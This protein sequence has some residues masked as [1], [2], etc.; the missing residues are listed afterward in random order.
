MTGTD[1]TNTAKPL[2]AIGVP[3]ALTVSGVAGT[4]AF[5]VAD[6]GPAPVTPSAGTSTVLSLA[7]VEGDTIDGTVA[8]VQMQTIGAGAPGNGA[9]VAFKASADGS[10]YGGWYGCDAP[11]LATGNALIVDGAATLSH[12]DLCPMT[13]GRMMVAYS[14]AATIETRVR[15][16][17]GVWSSAVTAGALVTTDPCALWRGFDGAYYVMA[18][19]PK[20]GIVAGT[21]TMRVARSGD[22]GATWAIQ[23]Y[24]AGIT[25]D[26][27]DDRRLRVA[28]LRGSIVAFLTTGTGVDSVVKQYASTDGVNFTLVSTSA[29]HCVVC[30]VRADVNSGIFYVLTVEQLTGAHLHIRK[31]G[32]ASAS[33]W[34]SAAVEIDSWDYDHP[35]ALAVRDEDGL[36]FAVCQNDGSRDTQFYQSSD[37]GVTWTGGV[38]ANFG[39]TMPTLGAVAASFWRGTLLTV[40]GD[41][42]ATVAVERRY[43]GH[44][45]ATIA[46]A[47]NAPTNWDLV[48]M[49]SDALS[50]GLWT[51]STTGSPTRTLSNLTGQKVV[52]TVSD[53]Q[54]WTYDYGVDSSPAIFRAVMRVTSGV[55]SIMLRC[56]ASSARLEVTLTDTTIALADA[57]SGGSIQT[58]THGISG[59]VDI[60]AVV[61]PANARAFVVFGPYGATDARAYTS[62]TAATTLH[63]YATT[64]IEHEIETSV[65]V[66]AYVQWASV[67]R[68]T[69]T[70]LGNGWTSPTELDPLPLSSRPTYLAGGLSVQ[71]AQGL[72]TLDGVTHTGG[73]TSPY[74]VE[75]AFPRVLP[76]PRTG[77]RSSGLQD[78]TLTLTLD[79]PD[80]PGLLVLDVQGLIGVSKFTLNG[81][82]V[83]LEQ[84][85]VYDG[86]GGRS[87]MPSRSGTTV[88]GPWVRADELRGWRFKTSAGVVRTVTGNSEGSLTRGSTIGEHRAVLYLSDVANT[89]T[90]GS[91]FLYPSRAVVYGHYAAGTTLSTATVAIV[92]ADQYGGATVPEGYREI[93][94]FNLCRAHVVG[95]GADLDD[96]IAI[97]DDANLQTLPN[98]QRYSARRMVD[99]QRVQFQWVQSPHEYR[100]QLGASTSPDYVTSYTS[101]TPV[102]SAQGIPLLLRGI[103]ERVRGDGLN[104]L[105]VPVLVCPS[106]ARK[107]STGLVVKVWNINEVY[108]RIVGPV[109]VE[110]VSYVGTRGTSQIAR[111]AAVTIERER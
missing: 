70:E 18:A 2:F 109:R 23:T 22:D 24:D 97:D 80:A 72:P 14:T 57:F 111:I 53:T 19:K 39:G 51:S 54:K 28:A 44:S 56:Y 98:G 17:A 31:L 77:W 82:S 46:G 78:E 102:A 106:V 29:T 26:H 25:V 110:N 5:T 68:A 20:P 9:G 7:V 3:Y 1:K 16:A 37:S 100:Q 33:V 85:F 103:T 13:A 32:T 84:G 52:C 35:A 27:G 63:A 93:A 92:S 94:L 59:D 91:G 61:D 38:I 81:V 50:T 105:D 10:T 8:T 58:L 104:R 107:S 55:G 76:T 101:G 89:V 75:A 41:G 65:N 66:T 4:G 86:V 71:L 43:G 87:V 62:M 30:D 48:W 21:Y 42:D 90:S 49:P 6:R 15:S 83:D 36:V 73:L 95:M 34:D 40:G 45:Q 64:H 88:Q 96:T 47:L 12:F 99:G 108:G 60:I 11:T 69:G 79:E 74:R 67:A